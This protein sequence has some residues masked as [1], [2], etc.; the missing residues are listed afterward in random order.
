MACQLLG[1]SSLAAYHLKSS[2]YRIP[3]IV[4]VGPGKN[5]RKLPA[6]L[7][8]PLVGEIPEESSLWDR[9]RVVGEVSPIAS[10]HIGHRSPGAPGFWSVEDAQVPLVGLGMLGSQDIALQP[11]II[12]DRHGP[13]H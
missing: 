5:Q 8:Q 4:I 7:A 12:A 10:V 2:P 1:S 13:S 9:R 3:G 6:V 11:G